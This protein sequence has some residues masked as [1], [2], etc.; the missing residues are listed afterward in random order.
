MPELRGLPGTSKALRCQHFVSI[1]DALRC[2]QRRR[3]VTA[4][5]PRGAINVWRD[6]AGRLRSNFC[7]DLVTLDEQIH[8][9]AAALRLWLEHWLP[10]MAKEATH[11]E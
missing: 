5:G 11:V 8:G 9:D 6:D 4:A 10:A 2:I 7:R 1:D 3:A